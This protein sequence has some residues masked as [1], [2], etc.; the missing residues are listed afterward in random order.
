MKL[1]YIVRGLPGSG[2]STLS[3]KMHK[4]IAMLDNPDY[5]SSSHW[6]ADMYFENSDGRYLF[7]AS[8]LPDAHQWCQDKV[9]IDM[10]GRIF[11]NG[12]FTQLRNRRRYKNIIFVTNTFSQQWEVEPYL[13]L[14]SKYGYAV[15]IIEC[16]G[17]H[18]NVHD[19]PEDTIE[20]MKAKWE[21]I[22]VNYKHEALGCYV[23]DH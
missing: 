20:T 21:P 5:C 13:K 4:F 3:A 19:V 16:Q 18:G 10:G 17:D 14:A 22:H 23:V 2:K 15:Q 12:L 9:E 8:K 7:D 1:L 11:Q 6:E